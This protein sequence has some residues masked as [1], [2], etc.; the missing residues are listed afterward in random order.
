MKTRA[1]API[2]VSFLAAAVVAIGMLFA[3]E[4]IRPST[5]FVACY[6]AGALTLLILHWLLIL[7]MD[8]TQTRRR[9]ASQD[10]G[11]DLV[12]VVILFAVAFGFVAAPCSARAGPPRSFRRAHRT[13]L[14]SRVRRRPRDRRPHGF[15]TPPPLS[16][17]DNRSTSSTQQ[18]S[19]L[20][21]H[22]LFFCHP[23]TARRP[24]PPSDP[25]ASHSYRLIPFRQ[26]SRSR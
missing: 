17:L 18:S 7:G 22:I 5:R 4:W 14:R 2:A 26:S 19:Q 9:A 6:D 15:L 25:G 3:P 1:L 21:R 16:Q 13:A 12:F 11:R 8:V 20:H 10:P 24:V 23:I